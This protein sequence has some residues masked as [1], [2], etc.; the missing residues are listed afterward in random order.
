MNNIHITKETFWGNNTRKLIT[1]FFGLITFLILVPVPMRC[2][3][4]SSSTVQAPWNPGVGPAATDFPQP[5]FSP[6]PS[7]APPPPL[8]PPRESNIYK[9][10]SPLHKEFWGQTT[11]VM[12]FHWTFFPTLEKE[13][14]GNDIIELHK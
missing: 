14:W 4:S 7:E 9:C 13:I 10:F 5:L 3:L 6:P 1:I 12:E 11:W 2:Q 8:L